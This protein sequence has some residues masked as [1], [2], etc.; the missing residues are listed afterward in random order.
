MKISSITFVLRRLFFALFFEVVGMTSSE[1]VNSSEFSWLSLALCDLRFEG[2]SDFSPSRRTGSPISTRL[3]LWVSIFLSAKEFEGS[4]KPIALVR[5]AK[6][7]NSTVPSVE[8]WPSATTVENALI[9]NHLSLML[10]IN[11]HARRNS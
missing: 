11:K 9:Y 2:N 8:N 6:A 4:L 1:T 7:A 10:Q 3:S 5:R